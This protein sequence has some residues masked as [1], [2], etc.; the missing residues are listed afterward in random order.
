MHE[1]QHGALVGQQVPKLALPDPGFGQHADHVGQIAHVIQKRPIELLGVNYIEQPVIAPEKIQ[2][3]I[4][5]PG[6]KFIPSL[7]VL[8]GLFGVFYHIFSP[9]KPH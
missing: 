1:I 8:T 4:H 9:R 7:K 2:F 3:F 6:I 5:G